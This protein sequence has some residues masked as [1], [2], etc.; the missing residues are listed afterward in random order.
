MK[1]KIFF[2]ILCIFIPLVQAETLVSDKYQIINPAIES[3]GIEES[4]NY[5][6]LAS[7]ADPTSF[8]KLESLNYKM[9]SGTPSSFQANVPTISCFETDTNSLDTN[10]AYPPNGMQSVC[11]TPG[12]YDRAKFE[13]D[14]ANNPYDT[15]Y[16]VKI[17]DITNSVTYY[18][19][20]DHSIA[21]TYTI[22]DFMDKCDLEGLDPTE[23]DCDISG[24]RENTSLQE[25]NIYGLKPNTQ[26]EIS[27][28]A[29]HGDFTQSQFSPISTTTT[30]DIEII[31]DID[32]AETD[33]ES[34][35]PYLIDLGVITSASTSTSKNHIW[36]DINTNYQQGI[37][38]FAKDLNSGLYETSQSTVIPSQSEDLDDI[39]NI[40]GGYGLKIIQANQS[41][42]G[43]LLYSSSIYN[44]TNLN[45]VGKLENSVM[46]LVFYTNSLSTNKG[47]IQNGRGQIAVKAR[48]GEGS[49]SNSYTDQ[50]DFYVTSN[51]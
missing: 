31:F 10:C 13:I 19:Q 11:G 51:L 27:A 4:T 39:S 21:T 25:T 50:I 48:A 28:S 14:S 29:L 3:G 7:I 42:L 38:V 2:T 46:N 33:I 45:E 23:P 24:S 49:I 6:L 9:S 17:V 20:A 18:L 37:S 36:L 22:N 12:C 15:L 40:D 44:T 35:P 1:T 30:T 41:S 8:A 26:Y 34:T 16:L 43:P 5:S 32:I 47:H